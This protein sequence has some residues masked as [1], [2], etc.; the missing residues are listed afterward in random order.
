MKFYDSY[1]NTIR[2]AIQ[3]NKLSKSVN[4]NYS[5]FTGTETKNSSAISGVRNFEKA[6]VEDE[7]IPAS[8]LRPLGGLMNIKASV[9]N[10]LGEH[11][12]FAHLKGTDKKELHY[13]ASVFID[14]K[15]STNLHKKY[16]LETIHIIT[17]TIQKAAIH[18]C[19][20][21][22][23]HIQRLQGDGVFIYF[24]GK[25]VSKKNAVENALHA[26]SFFTYFVKNDLKNIFEEDGI[27]DINTRIGIDFGDD[28]KVMWANY[29][30]GICS[31]LTTNSLHTSLASKM[32]GYAKANGIV[33]GDN[34]KEQVQLADEY[35]DY[36]KDSNG[37]IVKRYIF[38]D[39][40]NNYRYTQYA[41]DWYKYLK[42]LPFIK[43]DENGNLYWYTAEQAEQDRIAKLRQSA[44]A[45]AASKASTDSKGNIN[46]CSIGVKNQDH[47]FHYDK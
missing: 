12:D 46:D 41:F 40:P 39:V 21:F 32:Q 35:F 18:T 31:E 30:L 43:S 16:D 33:I 8:S 1:S 6:E 9:I 3:K 20:L 27:E 29:G 37:N 45:I 19:V 2:Q 25:N 13:I 10:K 44:L 34:V 11:P 24:G 38:E 4:E 47:R 14:I 36:V 5:N 15:G 17:N 26:T 23:G 42:S 7:S 22:G 28:D